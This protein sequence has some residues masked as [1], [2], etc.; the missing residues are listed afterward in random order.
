MWQVS[1]F[2]FITNETSPINSVNIPENNCPGSVSKPAP[3]VQVKIV[4]YETDEEQP[5]GKEGKIMVK[6]DLVRKVTWEILSK[7]L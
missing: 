7:R 2:K 6:G 3:G 1:Y 5:A 4:N